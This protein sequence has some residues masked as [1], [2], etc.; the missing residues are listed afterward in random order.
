MK[1]LNVVQGVPQTGLSACPVQ[2]MKAPEQALR[3]N[4]PE[5][6]GVTVSLQLGAYQLSH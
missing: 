5:K 1:A 6:I 2:H 3:S 4:S